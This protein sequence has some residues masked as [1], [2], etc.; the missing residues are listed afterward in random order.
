MAATT[1]ADIQ[2]VIRALK[3]DQRKTERG[4]QRLQ[5]SQQKTEEVQRKTEK[6]LQELS[7]SLEQSNGNFI[8]GDLLNIFKGRSIQANRIFH[9]VKVHRKDKKL[10]AEY[11]FIV[12][13]GDEVVIIEVKTTVS[14]HKLDSFI[15]KLQ[16]FK[17]HFPEY[18]DKKVYGGVAYIKADKELLENALEEGLFLIQ[19]PGGE[20][21]VT[22]IVNPDDFIPRIY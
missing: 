12:A 15:Q 22:T 13:N 2:K 1:M 14:S 21:K 20:N 7:K 4:F 3:E 19:A 16:L 18:R 11:D 8:E 5:E 17:K 10:E 9:R 6:A